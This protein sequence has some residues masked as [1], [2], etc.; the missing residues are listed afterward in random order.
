MQIGVFLIADLS[1]QS[2]QQIF[3]CIMTR[4]NLKGQSITHM[5][6]SIRLEIKRTGADQ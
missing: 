5:F 1:D 2:H 6:A 3:I 4:M